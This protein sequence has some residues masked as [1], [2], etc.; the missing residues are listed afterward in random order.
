MSVKDIASQSSVIFETQCIY[1]QKH[2]V[3]N[4]CSDDQTSFADRTRHHQPL[5]R[6]AFRYFQH[7]LRQHQLHNRHNNHHMYVHMHVTSH[8][9]YCNVMLAAAA[10]MF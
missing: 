5:V 3:T 7:P 10:S 1:E 6:K 9:D 8:I 2:W 4:I